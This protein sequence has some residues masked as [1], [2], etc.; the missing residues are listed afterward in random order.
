MNRSLSPI[1]VRSEGYLFEEELQHV[2]GAAAPL[3]QGQLRGRN[4]KWLL[5]D[6]GFTLGREHETESLFSIANGYI[7]SR[8]SL[9]EGSP[10]SAPA[11]FVA[12]IF[13]ELNIPGLE[14]N[15]G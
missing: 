13:E 9:A 4:P 1:D 8:G 10:L 15:S 5:V 14:R 6:G 12:G 3:L 11:T 2:N 7:G